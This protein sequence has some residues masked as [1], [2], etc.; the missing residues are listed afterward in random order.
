MSVRR[1][2]CAVALILLAT[3]FLAAQPAPSTEVVTELRVHGNYSIPDADIMRLAG[4]RNGRSSTTE[5][6]PPCP[7]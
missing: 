2:M 6:A 3:P 7:R 4:V 1:A 5:D